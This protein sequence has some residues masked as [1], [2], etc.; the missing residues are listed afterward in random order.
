M[1]SSD[2]KNVGKLIG[3]V[4]VLCGNLK[5]LATRKSLAQPHSGPHFFSQP[6]DNKPASDDNRPA[7]SPVAA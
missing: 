6:S 5:E 4:A 7:P 2:H 3:E 1:F